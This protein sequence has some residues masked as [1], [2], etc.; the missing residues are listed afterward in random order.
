MVDTVMFNEPRVKVGMA[1][2]SVSKKIPSKTTGR[3]D[4]FGRLKQAVLTQPDG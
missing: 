1:S 4:Y 2:G 3:A